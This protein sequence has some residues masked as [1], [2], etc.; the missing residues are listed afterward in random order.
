M[1]WAPGTGS[2]SG[3]AF[4]ILSFR[5]L[6]PALV[7]W[8]SGNG[9]QSDLWSVQEAHCCISMSECPATQSVLT[10]TV[11]KVCTQAKPVCPRWR[12]ACSA[13]QC[14]EIPA[15]NL[16]V[17]LVQVTVVMVL[18]TAAEDCRRAPAA[19]IGS[20]SG[21]AWLYRLRC[22]CA[23]CHSQEMPREHEQPSHPL[24][25]SAPCF[26]SG[27]GEKLDSGE[28]RRLVAP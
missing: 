8:G 18:G 15:L 16:I 2:K 22:P 12:S 19:S 26:L 3:S 27:L 5:K 9:L 17:L 7:G 20:W 21:I 1:P 24:H 4:A 25:A 10:A 23:P 11:H 13:A 6:C 28:I 14:F